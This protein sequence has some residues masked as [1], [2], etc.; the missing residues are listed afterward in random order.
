MLRS[1]VWPLQRHTKAHEMFDIFT[2]IMHV[3][4]M[5]G[6]TFLNYRSGKK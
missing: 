6:K 5:Y 3:V 2:G 1:K 4:A